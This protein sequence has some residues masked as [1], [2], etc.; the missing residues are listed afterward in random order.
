MDARRAAERTRLSWRRT[1][2]SATTVVLIAVIRLVLIRFGREV[3]A[4]AQPGLALVA[5]LL[6]GLAWIGI[7]AVAGR[8]VGQ[9][10]RG[11]SGP[12][13]RT[14]GVLALLVCACGLLGILVIG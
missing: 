8:R 10:D 11:T 3:G 14:P 2:L 6:I 4:P 12:L 13:R 9:L 1:T 7:L 5:A